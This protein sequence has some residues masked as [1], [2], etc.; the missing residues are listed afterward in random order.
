MN[1][2]ANILQSYQLMILDGALATELESRGCD[3]NDPLW[4][5]KVLLEKPALIK[6]VHADYFEA[7]ADCAITASYQASFEGFAQRGL[8]EEQA[9]DLLRLSVRLAVEARD[10]FW[11]NQANHAHRPKPIIAAS[12]GSYGA[13]L[14]DGS[15]YRGDYGLSEQALID[16]HRRRL[17]VLAD[18]E[19]DVI[20]CETVPCLIEAQA[21]TQ[22]LAEFPHLIAWISFSARDETHISYGETLAECVAWLNAFPQIV[23]VGVNCTH[24]KYIPDLIKSARLKTSKPVLVYPNSGEYYS[25]HDKAWHI[26][27]EQRI[28]YHLSQRWCQC[29]AQI[30]GGCC[31]TTPADIK[32]IA[33]WARAKSHWSPKL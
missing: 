6:Q 24:P 11:S 25:T 13:Y 10:E 23:A 8:S 29:G 22:L 33:N 9:A 7:G 1:P 5:A 31:R 26:H 30:I 2:I 19:A 20:A 3:L 17:S 32:Q 15:E 18:T 16:F 27:G 21:L 4:S 12:V 14:A 28:Y